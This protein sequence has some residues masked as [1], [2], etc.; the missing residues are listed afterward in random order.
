MPYSLAR[1]PSRTFFAKFSD[2]FVIGAQIER[3]GT[4]ARKFRVP[5]GYSQ[6]EGRP[7]GVSCKEKTPN[8][9]KLLRLRDVVVSVKEKAG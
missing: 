8:R 9:L 1:E 3:E 6:D 7:L 2:G 4:Q 5:R